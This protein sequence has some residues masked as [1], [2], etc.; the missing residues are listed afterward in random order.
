MSVMTVQTSGFAELERALETLGKA[1]TQK[2]SLRRAARKALQ[3]VA[4]LA[5]TLA[6]RDKGTLAVSIG[7]GTRLTRRQAGLHRRMFRDDR[8]AVEVFVGAG[9]LA[10]ATQ[11]EFGNFKDAPQPF[12]R[13]AWDAEGRAT[14]DRLATEL[15]ADIQRT[16]ARQAR[17]AA[18]LAARGG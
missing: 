12:M 8:A 7:I 17:Q 9:G 14:L 1:T 13:P 10:Q 3:P 18:R 15:W 2:A 16:A 4:N 11:M 5:E 6:P